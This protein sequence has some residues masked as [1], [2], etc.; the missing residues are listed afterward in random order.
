VHNK[1]F[2]NSLYLLFIFFSFSVFGEVDKNVLIRGKVSSVFDEKN[3]KII[4]SF[5][6]VYFIPRKY[7]P[8]D[9]QIKQGSSFSIELPEV[10][11]ENLKVKVKN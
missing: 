7:F 8:K 2:I 1:L 4:D 9:F 10:E 6:Q 5:E 3:V 11:L